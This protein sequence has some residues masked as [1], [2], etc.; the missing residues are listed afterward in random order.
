[1]MH[2]GGEIWD[3]V[4]DRV[5]RGDASAAAPTRGGVMDPIRQQVWFE[6]RN[7]AWEQMAE[8]FDD[9]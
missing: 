9:A 3:Q 6:V 1:M 5:F 2:D 8:D 4:W 7:H